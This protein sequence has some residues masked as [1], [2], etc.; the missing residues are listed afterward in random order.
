MEMMQILVGSHKRKSN[1]VLEL[2]EC[3][4]LISATVMGETQRGRAPRTMCPEVFMLLKSFALVA[5]LT[6]HIPCTLR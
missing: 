3:G 1:T 2:V 5:A 4:P 6:L